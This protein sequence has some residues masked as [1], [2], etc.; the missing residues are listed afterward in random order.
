MGIY[1]LD[2]QGRSL[3][4]RGVMDR[5]LKKA[6]QPASHLFTLRVWSERLGDDR[7][8]WRGQVEHVISGK[9]SSFRDWPAMVLFL[10]DMLALLEPGSLSPEDPQFTDEAK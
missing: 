7:I 6:R 9:S 8:E 5:S 3:R 10:Q 2:E 1:D 4:E